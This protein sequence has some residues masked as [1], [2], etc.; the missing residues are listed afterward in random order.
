MVRVNRRRFLH[1]AGVAAASGLASSPASA[2]AEDKAPVKYRLGIVTY[3][4]AA[5]WDVPTI[6]KVCKNVGLSPVELRT[7]HAMGSNRLSVKRSAARSATALPTPALRSG[8]AE[9][10]VNSTRPILP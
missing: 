10:S 5:K 4:I 3:N 8:A 7:T 1:A 2:H 9:R 6:V